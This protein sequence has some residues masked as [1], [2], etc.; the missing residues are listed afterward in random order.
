MDRRTEALDDGGLARALGSGEER[1]LEEV[2]ARHGAAVYALARRVLGDGG[3]AEDVVQEVFLRL[4]TSPER[5]DPDRG[6]LR[7]FLNREVHSRAIERLRSDAAR[8]RREERH[9]REWVE[10]AHDVEADALASIRS[11]SM[12]AALAELS[13]GERT[14]IVLA[15]FG[16]RTLSGGRGHARATGGDHQEPHQ[17]GA[18]KAGRP[19]GC[20]GTG[21]DVM[22]DDERHDDGAVADEV[23]DLLGAYVLD[24]LDDD[25]RARVE[26]L[27]REDAQARA[28][29]DR[30]SRVADALAAEVPEAEPPAGLWERIAAEAPA[31]RARS[32]APDE[33]MPAVPS[34]A[35]SAH[36][37]ELGA[38]RS[39][40]PRTV[41]GGA[42]APGG[43][44][45]HRRGGPR[46]RRADP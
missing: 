28:E 45:G 37:D 15:Y 9:D 36:P 20:R 7:S 5:F 24:A 10:P 39:P 44:C 16:G 33:S 18:R 26:A 13:E 30:L 19:A 21:G 14:A 2:Y 46:R 17:A 22:S 35:A 27:L 6:A 42:R 1:A 41:Q 11:D 43:G 34:T 32:A 38:R 23:S 8:S 25:E 40:T 3:R 31:R 4:W 29:V 12:K